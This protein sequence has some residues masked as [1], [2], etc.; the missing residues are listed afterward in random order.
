MTQYAPKKMGINGNYRAM[1]LY[2]PKEF[3]IWRRAKA[4]KEKGKTMES[5]IETGQYHIQFK[6]KRLPVEGVPQLQEFTAKKFEDMKR[7]FEKDKVVN[8]G[9]K[10]HLLISSLTT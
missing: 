6:F 10:I 2:W 9:I 3:K 8:E 1:E 4:N 7:A 5:M